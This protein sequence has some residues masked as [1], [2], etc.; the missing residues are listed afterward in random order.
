[1]RVFTI[2]FKFAWQAPGC[3]MALVHDDDLASIHDA[4]R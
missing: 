2:T 1:M 4:V 3:D